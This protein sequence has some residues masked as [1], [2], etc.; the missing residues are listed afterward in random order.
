LE[1][2]KAINKVLSKTKEYRQQKLLH[3]AILDALDPV[4]ATQPAQRV[5]LAAQAVPRISLDANKITLKKCV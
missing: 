5:D 1:F 2:V 4:W 3:T